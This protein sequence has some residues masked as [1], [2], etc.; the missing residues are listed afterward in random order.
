VIEGGAPVNGFYAKDVKVE[1]LG[2]GLGFEYQTDA[3][4]T[5][6]SYTTPVTV[7]G[8]G[9]HTVSY[10]ATNN[11]TGLVVVPIDTTAPTVVILSP[12]EGQ[13]FKA[14]ETVRARFECDDIG[15]VT[16]TGK[17]GNGTS[18]V[19]GGLL[20][21]SPG[22][23]T[24]VVTA[25][26]GFGR[27]GTASVSYQSKYDFNGFLSP[28]RMDARNVVNAGRTIPMK[29]QVRDANGFVRNVAIVKF[30][31]SEQVLCDVAKPPVVLEL[32]DLP[33]NGL[34]YNLIDEQFHYNWSTYKTWKT[35]CRNFK[36]LLDDKTEHVAQFQ[37][38]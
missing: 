24:L 36:V 22:P 38:T 25:K 10:R 37:F 21:T 29:W 23:K 30:I 32:L 28:V 33:L 4:A 7:T 15:V 20:D 31:S 16:C 18:I 35:Q 17:V 5:W 11:A 26:D 34:V 19:S 12:T 1:L 6:R 2:D 9:V 13:V 8:D 27:T 14:A 3:D